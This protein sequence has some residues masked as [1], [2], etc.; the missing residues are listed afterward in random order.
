MIAIGLF[1][2]TGRM[3]QAIAAEIARSKSSTL[4]AVFSRDG[5]P[6]VSPDAKPPLT[7]SA[8]AAIATASDVLIDF[9]MPLATPEFLAAAVAA[10]KPFMCGVTGLGAETIAALKAAARTIPVLYAPNTS[11]SLVVMKQ[12]TQM[13]A[14]LLSGFDYDI[15]IL[16]QHH[17][18]KKDAPSGTAVA[19]GQA[20]SKG[21]GGVK[22]PVFAAIRAGSI[23]GEHEV[24]FVGQGETIRLQH[25]VTDRAIFARGALA[26]ALWLTPKPPGFY[27]MED[28]LGLKTD[29]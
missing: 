13:A 23:V 25:S 27:G 18:M 21:N 26:A 28:V 17:R 16:D 1:G 5:K 4:A 20:V 2:Y 9:T 22:A 12:L 24:A 29:A 15:A 11:V 6:P 3:G 7:S 19:L 8:V 10:K 14:K